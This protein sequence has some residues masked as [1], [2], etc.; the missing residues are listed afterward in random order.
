MSADPAPG[1]AALYHD[2][3]CGLLSANDDGRIVGRNR[4]LLNWIGLEAYVEAQTEARFSHGV[5][6]TC[7]AAYLRTLPGLR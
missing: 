4:T 6:S 1:F 7:E 5:C 3:P 2:A